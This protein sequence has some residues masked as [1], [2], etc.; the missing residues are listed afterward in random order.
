MLEDLGR[1]SKVVST[2]DAT[3]IVGGTW[4]AIATGI[5]A[6]A[7]VNGFSGLI[8]GDAGQL[9]KQIGATLATWGYSFVATF[10][11]LKVLAVTMGLR[12]SEEE[13]IV[14]LDISQHGERGYIL[15]P[16][17]GGIALQPEDSIA[18]QAASGGTAFPAGEPAR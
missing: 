6:V 1:A 7:A 4:G 5:F 12:V 17:G 8:D 9:G 16:S 11:I 3:T 2:K 13:E 14:G 10:I 15:E 18:S